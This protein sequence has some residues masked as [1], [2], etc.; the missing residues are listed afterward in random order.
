M[1][2]FHTHACQGTAL[3]CSAWA[4]LGLLSDLIPRKPAGR[5]ARLPPGHHSSHRGSCSLRQAHTR[6]FG[7]QFRQLYWKFNRASANLGPVAAALCSR[8]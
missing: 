2:L 6:A 7:A 3:G 1:A 4:R 5:S 8:C